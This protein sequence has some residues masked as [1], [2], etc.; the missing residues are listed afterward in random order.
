MNRYKY[1][2]RIAY[3]DAK[4]EVYE[5]ESGEYRNTLSEAK[6]DH[7]EF[8]KAAKRANDNCVV[9]VIVYENWGDDEYPDLV[10][11]NSLMRKVIRNTSERV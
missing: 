1:C 8:V 6:K 5:D 7:A 4:G 11:M 10:P 3:T 2:A 9:D